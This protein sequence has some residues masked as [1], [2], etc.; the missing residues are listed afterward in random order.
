MSL[1]APLGLLGLI[2]I[3][4]L[5][6]I[7]IIK[8]NYQTKMIS[9]TYI[10][11]LSMKYRK[12]HVPISRINNILIFVCQLLILTLCGLLLARPVIE[13][14]AA[15]LQNEKIIIIDASASM[16]VKD[17][18]NTR[19]ERAV[20]E[21]KGFVEDTLEDGGCVSIILADDT[22][23]FIVQ[24]STSDSQDDVMAVLDG[25]VAEDLKCSYG[26]ANMTEAVALADEVLLENSE[27]EVYLF[28]GTTYIEK[29]GI[30]VENISRP[31]EEWNVA[32]LDCVAKYD[33]NNHY[34]IT[35]DV[36]CYG[37]TESITVFCKIHGA[38]G[39]PD[40]IEPFAKTEFFDP[41]E[42]EKTITFNTSDFNEMPLVSFDYLQIYVEVQD[43]FDSD[44]YF[45]VYG[46]QKQVIR[47][48]YASSDPNNFFRGAIRTLRQNLRNKWDI[49]FK[50]VGP[51]DPVEVSGFDFYIFEH[52]MPDVMPTD[53]VVLLADPDKAPQNSGL[54]IADAYDIQDSDYK[55][56]PGVSHTITDYVDL[57]TVEITRYIEIPS[58]DGYEHLAY[59]KGMPMIMLRDNIVV[60]D[61]QQLASKVVVWAFDLNYST[62]SLMPQFAFLVYNIFNYFIPSTVDSNSYEVGD[63]IT[64]TP[65][66]TDLEVEG[67]GEKFTF[68]SLPGHMQLNKP[69]F[70]TITQKPMQGE[71]FII[72]NFFVRIPNYESNITKEVDE[73]P[74]FTVERQRRIT[75]DDLIVYFAAAL[76]ALMFLEWFLQSR[77]NF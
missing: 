69:G 74:M 73:L 55:L 47:V 45:F 52:T 63:M 39:K 50:E 48:Q 31:E 76:V 3:G 71:H 20:D 56:A 19:F 22:P 33:N 30:K 59:Y 42:P 44:N 37:L 46:G 6:A 10:W 32:I 9:S 66:G 18:S 12:K 65:R 53:G 17:N 7:Y 13:A 77:V 43:S 51:A 25:L 23:E 41:S 5:I 15:A 34:E 75:F 60:V 27:A 36:G 54:Q 72:E 68:E 4:A 62:L 64:L 21:V 2:G 11:K 40:E 67:N 57:S 58:D 24:R 70:Y 38:N 35:V 49:E 29:N 61:G 14:E 1:L 26:S 28:T 8:P 16:L